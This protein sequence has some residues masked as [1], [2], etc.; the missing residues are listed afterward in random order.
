MRGEFAASF[1]IMNNAD[2]IPGNSQLAADCIIPA[3]TIN[4]SL[5]DPIYRRK[6]TGINNTGVKQALIFRLHLRCELDRHK[7]L[8]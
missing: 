7:G 5:N 1:E 8:F 2:K 6:L 4:N 3:F